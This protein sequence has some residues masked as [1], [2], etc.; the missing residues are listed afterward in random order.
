MNNNFKLP[1]KFTVQFSG[2]YQAK[3]NLPVSQGGM[4]M[5]GPPMMGAAQSSS[6]GYIKAT[7]GFDIA[8]KRTFLKND[9]ASVTLSVND[10]FK[11]RRQEQV[12]YS[13]NFI[14]NYYR[15]RDP[16][17]VRLNF[18]WRFGKMDMSLFKR[19]NMKQ[20]MQGA[21]EGMQQ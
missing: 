1:K 6:Q 2:T 12:S 10:I 16:Q 4:S 13:E 14:Q 11:T 7:Y 19:K 18:A 9:A 15:V 17:M 20:D 8:V 21:T 3:T 5:G